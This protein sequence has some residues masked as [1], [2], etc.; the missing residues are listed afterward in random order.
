MDEIVARVLEQ[1][2]TPS[3]DCR[4]D[5]HTTRPHHIELDESVLTEEMLSERLNGASSIGI[6]RHTVL[7]PSALD[8]LRRRHI[9][10]RR[11]TAECTIGTTPHTR[12]RAIVLDAPSSPAALIAG[13]WTQETVSSVD[14]AVQA[15]ISG[16]CRSDAE[17]IVVLARSAEAVACAANRNEKVRAA[18]VGT[19][20]RLAEAL[21]AL[22]PNVICVDPSDVGFVELKNILTTFVRGT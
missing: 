18:A 9:S 19:V 8:Y 20:L 14:D 17:H 7:T 15:T 16:I 5:K 22:A 6:A 1:I 13:G 21:S 3:C 12:R 2:G 4:A 10:C 11:R